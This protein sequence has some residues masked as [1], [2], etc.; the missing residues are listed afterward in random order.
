[1]KRSPSAESVT[2]RRECPDAPVKWSHA[3]LRLVGFG[4]R[5]RMR[6]PTSRPGLWPMPRP[7]P[8]GPFWS[9]RRFAAEL[10]AVI[11]ERVGLLPRI[12]AGIRSADDLYS[13]VASGFVASYQNDATYA[14]VPFL[15]AACFPSGK[16]LRPGLIFGNGR[17]F[18]G[19]FLDRY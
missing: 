12:G 1:M 3:V 11:R 18:R 5:R 4:I 8:L 7:D 13:C 17:R 2:A 19:R 15:L 16:H 9:P 10:S 6:R 14:G